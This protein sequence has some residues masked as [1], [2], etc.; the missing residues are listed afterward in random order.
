MVRNHD[1]DLD[2]HLLYE[3]PADDSYAGIAFTF[4]DIENMTRFRALRVVIAYDPPGGACTLYL[5]EKPDDIS[6]PA[7]QWP[8]EGVSLALDATYRDTV[9][10]VCSALIFFPE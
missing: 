1:L 6:I 8:S 10:V 9:P 3:V 2:Y 4:P 5:K 7:H